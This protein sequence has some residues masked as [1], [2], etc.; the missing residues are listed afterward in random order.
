MPRSGKPA[1]LRPQ[2]ILIAQNSADEKTKDDHWILF[3]DNLGNAESVAERLEEKGSMVT[4]VYAGTEY[5]QQAKN[6]ITIRANNVKDSPC[7]SEN[8]FR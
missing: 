6:K 2:S 1:K 5:Q 7:G 8:T 4:L 3:A